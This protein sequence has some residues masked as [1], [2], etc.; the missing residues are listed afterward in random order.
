[1]FLRAK[2]KGINDC[3]RMR[4]V[5]NRSLINVPLMHEQVYRELQLIADIL[6][7]IDNIESRKLL[8]I[9]EMML[10]QGKDGKEVN[11]DRK[12]FL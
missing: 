6:V 9:T 2:V 12:Y 5:V 4:L 8:K 7:I 10:E 1:M 3:I 11:I